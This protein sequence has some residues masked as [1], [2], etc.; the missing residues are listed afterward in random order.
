MR[1][2]SAGA[3][4]EA[5]RAASADAIC[6]ARRTSTWTSDFSDVNGERA[7]LPMAEWI[8]VVHTYR[9]GERR[10][11]VNGRAR[12]RPRPRPMLA[13][14]SPARMWIGGWYN[15]YDFV[16]DIDEVRISKVA[17]SADWVKLQYEN[18]KP[19]QTA[20]RPAGAAGQ[21]FLGLADEDHRPGGQERDGHR[22]GRRRTEGLLDPQA[23]RPGNDRRRGPAFTSRFD[24]GRVV[25]DQSLTLQFKAVY[26]DEVKT[27]DIPVTIKEDIPEPVF[28]LQ[29]PA[30]WDG[31]ETIE[32]VPQI[33]NLSA[34][35]AKGAGELKYA[36]TVS[37]IA[38]IKEI[39]PGKL[40]LKRAQNSGTMTVTA[41]ARATAAQPSPRDHDRGQ[42]AEATMP[43][44]SGRRPRM[45]SP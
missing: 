13:I 12:R 31:R 23:R 37:G 36:W 43:G 25:G 14:K 32:V 34:M 7:R 17:R 1:P 9:S 35:Q 3:T 44:S 11:Y 26:A 19:L 24:A 30:R 18:Q 21:R 39:V 6:A 28:T 27:Q 15:N 2:S 22:Q 20:G 41:G 29:A 42:G 5:A 10:I 16:G 33:A 8:H 38:V 45:R 4:R 40:I